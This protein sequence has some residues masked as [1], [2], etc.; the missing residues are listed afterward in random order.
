MICEKTSLSWP[1]TEP[2]PDLVIVG[3]SVDLTPAAT[4]HNQLDLAEKNPPDDAAMP[5]PSGIS[6]VCTEPAVTAFAR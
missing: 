5:P 2:V 3:V 6:A 1:C 4:P